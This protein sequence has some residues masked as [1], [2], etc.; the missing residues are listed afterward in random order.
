M[1]GWEQCVIV[2]NVGRDP[3]MRYLQSGTAVATFSV[4]VTTRW[5]DRNTNE[6]REKTN[7]YNVSCW[8]KLA[9]IA[10]QYIKK[11][12][13][14]MVVGTVSAR[15]YAGN[16]GQPRASLDLRADNFQMLGSSGDSGG[17]SSS[18]GGGDYDDYSPPPQD[19]DDIPF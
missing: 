11:G 16:D 7:W 12:T 13:P 6:R 15:A 8:N 1:A 18:S 3:E 10:N 19:M 9:E 2:G 14:I 17:S 5:T 4:A